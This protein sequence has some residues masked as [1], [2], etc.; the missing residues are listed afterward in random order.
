[1]PWN[2]DVAMQ[3]LR[4]TY[5][6]AVSAHMACVRALTEATLRGDVP[7]P[8]LVEAERTAKLRLT[9]ARKKLHDAMAHAIT[10][11]DTEP[12]A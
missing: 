10:G 9:E 4:L 7:D 11:S 1:M 12:S 3:A 2:D 8:T 6:A 5:N